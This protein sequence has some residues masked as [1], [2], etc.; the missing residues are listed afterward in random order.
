MNT[1]FARLCLVVVA[2]L[3]ATATPSSGRVAFGQDASQPLNAPT[4]TATVSGPTTVEVRWNE[5]ENAA[6]YELYVWWSEYVGWEQI[7]NVL[8]GSS[9]TH[10]NLIS[11]AR[12]YYTIR[13]VN[14]HGVSPW[15][16]YAKAIPFEEGPPPPA[17]T[18]FAVNAGIEK[19]SVHWSWDWTG[20]ESAHPAS[21]RFVLF[22]WWDPG[23]GWQQVGHHPG[24][25]QF[26]HDNLKSGTTYYYIVRG[27]TSTGPSRWSDIKSAVPLDRSDRSA[28]TLIYDNSGGENWT[29]KAN[30]LSDRPLNEWDGIV[31]DGNGRVVE[32]FLK[33]NNL[34]GVPLYY[35]HYLSELRELDLSGNNLHTWILPDVGNLSKL[36]LLNLGLNHLTG[37]IPPE[38]GKLTNLRS[39]WLGFNHLT[40]SIPPEL[41]KLTNLQSLFLGNNNLGG[42]VPPELGNLTELWGL[43]LNFNR[44][45]G[46]IPSEL[47]NL[48][49]L[50]SLWIEGNSFTGCLPA[51]WR[52]VE[53]SDLARTGLPFCDP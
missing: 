32:L 17:P 38:L 33:E 21:Y 14:A 27:E 37:P 1:Q 26:F 36:E 46:M 13:A 2:I 31:T 4:L 10:G 24:D 6:S 35:V 7:G 34:T 39:L 20:W 12:Y 52:D 40:G 15:S 16:E 29:N 30:W 28:L 47:G 23:I 44:L 8:T 49:H 11:G 50:E 42:S 18:I 51:A 45:D 19:I 5:T 3:F 9:Y 22:T 43:W 53:G 41:G 25:T 48:T